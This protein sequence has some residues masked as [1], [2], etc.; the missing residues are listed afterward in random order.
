M[1][2]GTENPRLRSNPPNFDPIARAYRW[3]EY[4]SF[5]STLER[6]RFYFL[7]VCVDARRGLVLGDGD[8]RFTARLLA[9][10]RAVQIDAVDAS[11]VML[12]LLKH[13]ALAAEDGEGRL[14][15]IH[16]DLRDFIPDRDGYDLIVSHFFLDCLTDEDLERM[17]ARI[18]PYLTPDATW[19]VSEF[20]VP[21]KGWRSMAAGALIRF[22]YLAFKTMTHLDVRQIPD[23]ASVLASNGFVRQQQIQFL[24]GV[25]SAERW[26]KNDPH[27]PDLSCSVGLYQ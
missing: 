23:Y 3:M 12:G 4:L 10:N 26:R 6:C 24:G 7:A 18:G 25:L 2:S 20:S 14:R 5:G 16:A 1:T 19:I 17:V 9:T 11:A 22:L 13:R 15:T 27:P 21:Q 8:G